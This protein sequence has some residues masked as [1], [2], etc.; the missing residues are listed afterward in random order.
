MLTG[1]GARTIRLFP[2]RPKNGTTNPTVDPT[3]AFESGSRP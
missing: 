3:T 2:K 1:I